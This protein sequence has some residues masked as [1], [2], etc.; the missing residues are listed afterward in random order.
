M[1]KQADVGILF[2]P[3]Q[4]VIRDYPQFPVVTDYEELKQ[5]LA[6]YI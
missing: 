2:R 1:L 4:N 5:L 3:P 6:D